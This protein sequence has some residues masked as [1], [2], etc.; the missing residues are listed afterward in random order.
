MNVYLLYVVVLYDNSG[1]QLDKEVV[2]FSTFRTCYCAQQCECECNGEIQTSA[3]LFCEDHNL[4]NPF[5]TPDVVIREICTHC[6][7]TDSLKSP[8]SLAVFILVCLLSLGMMKMLF[9]HI[10]CRGKDGRPI[11]ILGVLLGT[12]NREHT[13]K[14][15]TCTPTI[16]VAHV[17]I[18]K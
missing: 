1:S 11:D 8:F 18:F 10:C 12:A 2:T 13:K 4:Q 3:S 15:F 9:M 14:Y 6:W 5:W 17:C 7:F 16:Q